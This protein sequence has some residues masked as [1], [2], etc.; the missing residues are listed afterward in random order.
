[1]AS[2]RLFVDDSGTREYDDSRNYDTSGKSL[3]FVYGAILIDQDSS[4]SSLIPS[5]RELKRLTFGTADVEV[6][7]NWLRM[8]HERKAPYLEPY[9]LTLEKL[10]AFVDSYYRLLNQAHLELLGSVANKLHAQ[11]KY[12]QPWYAPTLAYEFLMQRAVQAVP[13]GSSLAVTIDDISGKTPKHTEYKRLL[14]AHHATLMK[15]GSRLQPSISFACMDSP[16]RFMLSQQSDLVQ[17]AD[18][19]SYNVHRQFRDHGEDWE[20]MR[21]DHHRARPCR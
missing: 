17:A 7:S 19:I 9:S 3:Y 21:A 18:L 13:T 12:V 4:A 11:E 15:G 16:V 2:Y 10:A 20:A 14:R 5:L 6:K 1:M 8:P